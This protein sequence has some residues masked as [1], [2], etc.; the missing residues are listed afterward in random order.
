M[1]MKKN[2]AST[3]QFR[4]PL[5]I[6]TARSEAE[7][8]VVRF[9]LWILIFSLPLVSDGGAF[10]IKNQENTF[11]T[12]TL[13]LWVQPSCVRNEKPRKHLCNANALP[14]CPTEQRLR[15][16]TNKAPLQRKR[17]T[18]VSNRGAFAMKSQEST[19][20]MQTL[21][22]LPRYKIWTSDNKLSQ[23]VAY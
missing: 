7:L 15:R 14:L 4:L 17:C 8:I 10:A 21:H 3:D 6:R 16:K 22:L 12:R 23:K 9:V 5:F 2:N 13:H 11:A 1:F 18:F 20:T 19:F